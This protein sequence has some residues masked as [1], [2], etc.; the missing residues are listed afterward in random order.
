MI[1]VRI[2][3]RDV[4][5]LCQEAPGRIQRAIVRA[6]NRAAGS[7]RT[8]MVREIARDTG[9]KSGTVR[10]QVP[11]RKA[12]LT[13]PSATISATL[14]RIPLIDFK[15]RGPEPSRGKGRGVSYNLP[16]GAGRNPNA[17]IATMGSGHRGV[18]VRA[19]SSTKTSAGAWSKNLP[20]FQLFG[21]SLGHVFIKY[22]PVGIAKAEDAFIAN[23]KHELVFVGTEPAPESFSPEDVT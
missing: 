16:S 12:T 14:K 22:Q 19:A 7:A 6:L 2:D 11:V 21:P 15:A 4:G 17:F 20:I 9:L 18:F 10:D 1:T 8:A 13:E 3:D 23:L 5:I